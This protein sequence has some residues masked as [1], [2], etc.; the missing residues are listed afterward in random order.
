MTRSG[1]LSILV[2]ISASGS[3]TGVL[4]VTVLGTGGIYNLGLVVVVALSGIN[5]SLCQ[6]VLALIG[7]G[8]CGLAGSAGGCYLIFLAL[9]NGSVVVLNLVA[10][11]VALAGEDAITARKTGRLDYGIGS[12]CLL[13]SERIYN[14]ICKIEYGAAINGSVVLITVSTVPILAVTLFGT[15][16]SLTA[17]VCGIVARLG[18]NGVSLG[19]LIGVS[20]V[21][22]VSVTSG[23]VPISYVT[24][25][26]ASAGNT[27][28]PGNSDML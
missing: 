3:L 10:A 25:L 4:G 8:A 18:D 2:G 14:K 23:A 26:L 28:N 11:S 15:G 5:Y 9:A 1:N 27:C 12:A 16:S 21:G 19:H 13:V 6:A 22:V 20:A 17:N 24:V 7:N